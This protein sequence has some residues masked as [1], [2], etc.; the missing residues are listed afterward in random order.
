M[1][2]VKYWQH[3]LIQSDHKPLENLNINARTDKELGD[4]TYYL[5]QYNLK[6]K[7][8]PGKSNQEADCLSRNPVL[9]PHENADDCL[10]VV[11]LITLQDIKNDQNNNPEVEK[12]TN[13]FI[14]KK[15]FILKK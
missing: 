14:K 10:K 1:E 8:N 12:N 2:A 4:L 9:E 6:I 5:S 11:N 13:K 3:W 7:Y 15:K